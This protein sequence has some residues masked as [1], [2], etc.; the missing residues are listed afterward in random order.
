VESVV[1]YGIER[2]LR[3]Q[4]AKADL[5][6][7][8]WRAVAD[9]NFDGGLLSHF[10]AIKMSHSGLVFPSLFSEILTVLIFS[11]VRVRC[12]ARA[13]TDRASVTNALHYRRHGLPS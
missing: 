12:R 1:K 13:R 5:P 7:L 4:A 2:N 10:T 11:P 3:M 8:H 9:R 6:C